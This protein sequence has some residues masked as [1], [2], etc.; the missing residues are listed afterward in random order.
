[1]EANLDQRA[2]ERSHGLVDAAPTPW[3]PWSKVTWINHVNAWK[4][5]LTPRRR[6]RVSL[7]E[8]GDEV[9]GLPWRGKVSADVFEC[10]SVSAAQALKNWS[11]PRPCQRAPS[12]E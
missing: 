6:A 1:V 5:G 2:A 11:K 4:G 7:D 12:R 9:R 10:A 3:L 8:N